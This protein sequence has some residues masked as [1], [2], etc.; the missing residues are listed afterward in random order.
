M[1]SEMAAIKGDGPVYAADRDAVRAVKRAFH[2]AVGPERFEDWRAR[3]ENW[4]DEGMYQGSASRR[5]A[6][7]NLAWARRWVSWRAHTLG[8]S[9]ALHHLFDGSIGTGRNSHETERVGKKY[10]WL[11]IYE[12]AARMEDNLAVLPREEEAGPS[13]LRNIDPSMLRERT[14]DDGWRSSSESSFWAPHRPVVEAST[15]GEALGWLH[16]DEAILDGPENIEITDQ[17]GRQWLVLTGL[18]TWEDSRDEVRSE[19]WRRV[20]CTIVR[21]ADRQEL[22]DLLDGVHMTAQHD[23]PVAAVDKFHMHLGEHP[24][25]WPDRGG[26]V[27]W[28]AEWRPNSADWEVPGL[29]VRPPTAEYTA[30]SGGYDYSITQ[31]ITLNLPAGWLM[32]ALGLRLSDGRSIEYRNAADDVV[33]MDPSVTRDGRSAALVERTA[34]LEMLRRE[35]L[36]AVW[37]LA[38]EKSVFGRLHS[39]GFGG[40]SV[41]TRIFVS[42]GTDLHALPRFETFEKPSRRQQAILLGQDTEGFAD[43][44]E[45]A[46]DVEA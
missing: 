23:L 31:N 29:P 11:A 30:E 9:E 28:L 44:E 12:L 5:P 1:E 21:T 35:D 7:F 43:D 15:P 40:R 45:D 3:A 24:W 16:S 34:F 37:A 27:G 20:G 41:F 46:A 17:D 38:G 10:Q 6:G 42:S 4:R 36:V 32:D 19:A 33:F 8:W 13:R 22:L 2:D 25:A 18:E 39:D 26:A 14:E